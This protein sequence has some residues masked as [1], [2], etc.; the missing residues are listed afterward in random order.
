MSRLPASRLEGFAD[1][2]AARP[3]QPSQF[4][5]VPGARGPAGDS[6]H[7]AVAAP[8]PAAVEE[9]LVLPTAAEMEAMQEQARQE[10][11][12]AG[13]REGLARGTQEGAVLLGLTEAF[14]AELA[15]LDEVVA[16]DVT[17]LALAVAQRVV[18]QTF[19]HDPALVGHFV[20]QA[21]QALP[22]NLEPARI[23]LNPV[24][25]PVVEGM[26]GTEFAGRRLTFAASPDL[27]RGGCRITTATT[28][29]DG[30][31][32]RRWA[33]VTEVLGSLPWPADAAEATP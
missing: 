2:A 9:T 30:S 12:E 13:Y 33:R 26:V 32:E 5:G 25:L 3:W 17:A 28:D 16:G 21:L 6:A 7:R 4:D 15:R 22:S 10:G 29:L 20:E 31:V 11:F 18:G 8:E 19:R 23:L 14:R 27:A 24:D 1:A